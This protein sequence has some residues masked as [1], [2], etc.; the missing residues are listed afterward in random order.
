VLFEIHTL[1]N[2]YIFLAS[3]GSRD[4][5]IFTSFGKSIVS[6][7]TIKS[8]EL[9]TVFFSLQQENKIRVACLDAFPLPVVEVQEKGD[10][11]GVIVQRIRGKAITAVRATEMGH[12]AVCKERNFPRSALINSVRS[13]SDSSQS[14][15]VKTGA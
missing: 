8:L 6:Q 10:R 13:S 1:K 5:E 3:A 7:N 4:F 12:L 9:C 15:P 11:V 14:Y 2:V